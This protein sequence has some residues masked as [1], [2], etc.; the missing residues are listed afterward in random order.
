MVRRSVIRREV[1][2]DE[3]WSPE[4]ADLAWCYHCASPVGPNAPIPVHSLDL[5]LTA[6]EFL[7]WRRFSASTRNQ[8]NRALK[9]GILFQVWLQPDRAIL[10][11]FFSF[12]RQ[13]M[14]ERG[15]STADPSGCKSTMPED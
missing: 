13:F 11:D 14:E 7:I 2:F 12:Y 15:V 8:I 6:S 9:D 10:E 4:G 5:N 1:W 3:R